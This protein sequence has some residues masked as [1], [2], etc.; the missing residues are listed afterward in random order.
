MR[1]R[2][3]AAMWCSSVC[4]RGSI[5]SLKKKPMTPRNTGKTVSQ[6]F[7]RPQKMITAI[8]RAAPRTGSS[9]TVEAISGSCSLSAYP[10]ISIGML[11]ANASMLAMAVGRRQST[12]GP[13]FRT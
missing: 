9:T 8:I 11:K 4:P 12:P 10:M 6:S 2:T 1:Y 13:V 7:V 5:T 3:A